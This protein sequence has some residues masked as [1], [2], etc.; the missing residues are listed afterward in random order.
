MTTAT[1]AATMTAASRANALP[2][3]IA[4]SVMMSLAMGMRQCLGLFL[5]P[6]T[7]ALAMS[8]SASPAR[9]RRWR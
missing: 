8:A 6:M 2:I 5:P 4:A 9:D 3:L 7:Q 1:N